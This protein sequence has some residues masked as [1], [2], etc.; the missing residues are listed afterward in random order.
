MC[1]LQEKNISDTTLLVNQYT[2]LPH[3]NTPP[4]SLPKLLRGVPRRMRGVPRRMHGVLRRID[5]C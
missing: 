4:P 1:L 5:V 3:V 2:S